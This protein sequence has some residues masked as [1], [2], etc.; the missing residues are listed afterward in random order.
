M[1]NKNQAPEQRQ[2]D[3]QQQHDRLELELGIAEKQ[4]ALA[5]LQR[6]QLPLQES[7]PG[8]EDI[9]DPRLWLTDDLGRPLS[10]T[11]PNGRFSPFADGPADEHAL[12]N[13]RNQARNVVVN[14]MIA[15]AALEKLTDYV[16]GKGF[17]Y[18]VHSRE[19]QLADTLAARVQHVIESFLEE[20]HFRGQ[21]EREIFR[22]TRRDGEAFLVFYPATDGSTQLRI[23]EPVQVTEP[24]AR[25]SG[26]PQND[27]WQFGV[28]TDQRDQWTVFG[29][30]VRWSD[31]PGDTEYIPADRV[32]HIKINVDRSSKRG[33][34]DFQ[35][36]IAWLDRADKLLANTAE[37]AAIQAAIAYIKEHPTGTTQA[38]A[39]T[40]R[41][42]RSQ[43][44]LQSENRSQHFASGTILTPSP[45]TQYKP[46][47]L[48]SSHAPNFIAIQQAILR[49]IG[50][51]WSMPEYMI[52]GDAS[53]ANFASTLVS[54][55]PFVKSCEAKQ[56][57]YV[58]HY[59][60]LLWKVVEHASASGRFGSDLRSLSAI[61]QRVCLAV[62]PAQL[63]VRD[64]QQSTT[65]RQSLNSAGLLSRQTWSAQE[66]LDWNQ[67]QSNF[68]TDNPKQD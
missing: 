18:S 3:L 22:R 34:S 51:R 60:R 68:Q 48:G 1:T 15:A 36:I 10:S 30:H 65:I 45:G 14:N 50:N 63:V 4:I 44:V 33:I 39:E 9:V 28:H 35:P 29:Y 61:Q 46:G 21:L 6:N 49:L 27:C 47:P 42:I 41:L 31:R 59:R 26:H 64:P 37:G 58:E 2:A 52:S 11:L 8:G 40:S 62:E 38:Q 24:V 67:E 12:G 54:E 7:W 13:L 23:L 66:N 20:N 5:T 43:A 53:N 19:P 25:P 57:F 16:V 32:L 17:R 55:S 56:S